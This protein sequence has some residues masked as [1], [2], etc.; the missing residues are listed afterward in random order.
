MKESNSE[1]D[2]L[3]STSDI[4]VEI[5]LEGSVSITGK[6]DAPRVEQGVRAALLLIA[7]YTQVNS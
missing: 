5:V 6:T 1:G 4:I 7:Y 3:A 2:A